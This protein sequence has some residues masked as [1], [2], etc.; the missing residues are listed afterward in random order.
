MQAR[1]E[2]AYFRPMQSAVAD[3]EKQ[4]SDDDT[5]A[6]LRPARTLPFCEGPEEQNRARDEMPEARGVKRAELNRRRSGSPG[7]GAPNN[8]NGEEG[9][10]HADTA[11]MWLGSGSCG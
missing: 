8:I 2:P 10:N 4:K 1:W 5:G 6:K 3:Q 11:W 7:S 9:G